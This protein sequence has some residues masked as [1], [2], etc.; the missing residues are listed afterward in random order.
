ML[1]LFE[2]CGCGHAPAAM[3][4]GSQ[5]NDRYLPQG[6]I[7]FVEQGRRATGVLVTATEGF[8]NPFS[9]NWCHRLVPTTPGVLRGP[10]WTG[11]RVKREQA[12]AIA[13]LPL[14]RDTFHTFLYG[15][16][17]R[18]RM[19]EPAAW[20]LGTDPFILGLAG[21]EPRQSWRDFARD[22]TG[23]GPAEPPIPLDTF[24]TRYLVAGE[25]NQPIARLVVF[26]ADFWTKGDFN[27]TTMDVVTLPQP[28]PINAVLDALAGGEPTRLGEVETVKM[29][30][31][32][33]DPKDT[34]RKLLEDRERLLRQ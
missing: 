26:P 11:G 12:I 2:T 6:E 16:G 17:L 34:A 25:L 14:Y 23:V 5:G 7:H 28:T 33:G 4:V 27:T 18:E 31:L 30:T 32:Y 8:D 19:G 3:R 13:H 9:A 22:A 24:T 29:E 21:V 15:D 10:S 1:L 20:V